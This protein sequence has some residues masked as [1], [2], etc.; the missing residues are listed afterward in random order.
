MKVQRIFYTGDAE[1]TAFRNGAE[2]VGV[3]SPTRFSHRNKEA[4]VNAYIER[5]RVRGS[6][7]KTLRGAL[8]Y[9]REH[10]DGCIPGIK[11]L[12]SDQNYGRAY[13]PSRRIDFDMRYNWTHAERVQA[14][15]RAIYDTTGA[16]GTSLRRL[17]ASRTM[18]PHATFDLRQAIE[19][20]AMGAVK[21]EV[22]A[23]LS[24]EWPYRQSNSNW[25]GGE[26]IV[27]VT[28][29]DV[30]DASGDSVR[31]WS[32][33][34]KWSGTNSRA[35]VTV[36]ERCLQ[37][38]GLHPVIGGLLTLDAERVG[39]REYKA[40]WVE[41][42]R[43]FALKTVEGWI[44]RGYHVTGGSVTAARKKAA[45]ARHKRLLTLLSARVGT[46]VNRGGYDLSSVMVTRA[47]SI[48]A[49]NCSAGTDSFIEQFWDQ[50]DG[51]AA[52]PGEELLQLRNDAHTRA[53]LCAAVL[54]ARPAKK[55]NTANA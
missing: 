27:S 3:A 28:I 48:A 31:V 53:A 42:G 9:G 24:S 2:G 37:S 25:A 16:E 51:R 29:G 36:T 6:S 47:D 30:P 33:N 8:R 43:G 19:A 4:V 12:S 34:G 44:I 17:E 50:L 15:A 45:A 20:V 5:M 40:V 14:L 22:V 1:S 21:R 26:H 38:L 55:S 7:A 41:Q 54:R 13:S 23:A 49:G 18:C 10:M 46:R 52:V 39:L 35:S 11:F 32:A